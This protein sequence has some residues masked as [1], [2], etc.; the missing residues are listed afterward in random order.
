MF[1]RHL[2]EAPIG[3]LSVHDM[4][5]P[6]SFPD[7]DRKLLQSPRHIEKIRQKFAGTRQVFDLYFVNQKGTQYV[8][9]L[10]PEDGM[11]DPIQAFTD[12][13]FDI[14]KKWN[15]IATPE[16][17][18]QLAGLDVHPNPDGISVVF[19]SNANE[20]N[21]IAMTPWIIAHRFAHAITEGQ[22][23]DPTRSYS[24]KLPT[25]ETVLVRTPSVTLTAQ[26]VA[27]MRSVRSGMLLDGE[28]DEELIAQYLMQGK[29]TFRLPANVPDPQRSLRRR[30]ARAEDDVNGVIAHLLR[31]CVGKI[32]ISV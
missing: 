11:S 1:L 27:T 30:L 4:D 22:L 6:G 5:A 12:D 25:A 18:K 20:E 32:L 10:E 2:F 17:V 29:V 8:R 16:I 9:T 15:G 13:F 21:T 14:L 28:F 24:N 3:H 23:T 19:L 31:L 26:E 7:R